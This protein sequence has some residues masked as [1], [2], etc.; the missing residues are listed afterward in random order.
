MRSLR[1]QTLVAAVSLLSASALTSCKPS[2]EAH[3]AA[4][5]DAAP[6]A[7][8]P[9]AW[10]LDR[11]KQEAQLAASSPAFHGFH[12]TDRIRES[13][14]TFVNRVVE[15]AGKNYKAVHY[16]HGSGLAAADVDGD[17]L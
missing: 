15:D 7:D 3:A 1:R 6:P 14:I 12:F 17:G 16:D 9:P 2:K 8:G 4:S 10:L 5:S 11:G 13:G